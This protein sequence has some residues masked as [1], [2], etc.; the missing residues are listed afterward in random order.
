MCILEDGANEG[1]GSM[2]A[3]VGLRPRWG[4]SP[5]I[6]IQVFCVGVFIFHLQMKFFFNG[7]DRSSLPI[8]YKTNHCLNC[9]HLPEHLF[10]LWKEEHSSI[11]H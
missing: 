7:I 2:C 11:C 9:R 8:R 1:A 4:L 6:L 3:E 10:L 5:G